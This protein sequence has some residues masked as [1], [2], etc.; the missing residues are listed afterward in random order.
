[1]DVDEDDDARESDRKRCKKDHKDNVKREWERSS[2][3]SDRHRDDGVERLTTKSDEDYSVKKERK[4]TC[5]VVEEE[6]RSLVMH[7]HFLVA[8]NN[9]DIKLYK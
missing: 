3:R 6:T 9:T 7:Y 8:L 4:R 2:S 1:M 5:E